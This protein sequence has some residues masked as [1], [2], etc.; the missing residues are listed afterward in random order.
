MTILETFLNCLIL[1]RKTHLYCLISRL[2]SNVSQ[3]MSQRPKPA[4]G[5]ENSSHT[6]VRCFFLYIKKPM[7]ITPNIIPQIIVDSLPILE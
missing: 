7:P 6:P 4:M 3:P 2:E 1:N 5:T